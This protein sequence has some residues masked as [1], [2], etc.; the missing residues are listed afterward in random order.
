MECCE[1][2]KFQWTRSFGRYYLINVSWRR[3]P[4]WCRRAHC[5]LASGLE[6]RKREPEKIRNVRLGRII[7]SPFPP[8]RNDNPG[9]SGLVDFLVHL[10]READGTHDAIS[11]LLVQ[12][13]LVS[14]PV[15]LDNLI[16]SVNKRFHRGHGSG[17]APVGETHHLGGQDHLGDLEEIG[18]ALYILLGGG[19]LTVE[20]GGARNLASLEVIGNGLEAQ[21]LGGFGIEEGGRVRRQVGRD[22]GLVAGQTN[23]IES[24]EYGCKEAH[25]ERC[26]SSFVSHGR[27][28]S[29]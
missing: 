4:P 17:T 27:D 7:D 2:S 26:N 28:W 1:C 8:H 16:E 25:I 21:A 29:D 12:D 9:C 6:P 3:L 11:K 19:G 20:Q 22:G 10:G 24:F 23:H 5:I 18:Q 15:V 13:S 14:V